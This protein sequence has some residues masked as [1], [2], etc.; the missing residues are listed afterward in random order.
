M[1]NTHLCIIC[2]IFEEFTAYLKWTNLRLIC[3]SE[4]QKCL[5][6]QG[7]EYQKLMQK[8]ARWPCGGVC[9]R[10]VG[11]NSIQCTTLCFKKMGTLF[12]FV[13]IVC[14]VDRF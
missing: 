1:Y 12:V 3:T 5:Q 7:G 6:L 4:R 9:G 10:G 14:V 13:I 11:S 8:A 2:S